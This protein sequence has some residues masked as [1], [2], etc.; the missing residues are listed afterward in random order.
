MLCTL[1]QLKSR[2]G[3]TDAGDDAALT[4]V[5]EGV[6]AQLARAGGF[7]HG[8]APCL[9]KAERT[10]HFS[11]EPRTT[12]LYLPA[13]PVV[14]VGELKEALYG[15]FADADALV[16]G[17]DYQLDAARGVLHR[18]GY[19]LPGVRTVRLIATLGY[20]PPDTYLADGYSQAA[21]EALL[22]ADVTE[23]ALQQAAFVWSRRREYGIRST[24]V[25]GGSVTAYAQDTLLPGPRETM[26][27]LG[28]ILPG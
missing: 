3:V 23:A 13:R 17:T 27:R 2:I 1:D 10:L 7:V 22:P 26:Q 12:A 16:E 18:V 24:G 28:R 6:S 14:A 19:W 21:G 8:G 9:E 15:A 25:Q 11:P 4:A 5:I 20:T